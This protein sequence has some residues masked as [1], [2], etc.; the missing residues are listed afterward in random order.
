MWLVC[1]L[2][3]LGGEVVGRLDAEVDRPPGFG[4]GERRREVDRDAFEQVRPLVRADVQRA[5]REWAIAAGL[6]RLGAH[7]VL[8]IVLDR[9]AA[10]LER[11][12]GV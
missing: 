9:L 2:R 6:R 4:F 8:V 1:L 10:R 3:A 11:L 5:G 7:A 12:V